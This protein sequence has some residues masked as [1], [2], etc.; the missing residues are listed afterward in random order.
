MRLATSHHL[1]IWPA[2]FNIRVNDGEV[3]IVNDE[4]GLVFKPGDTVRVTGG[5][6]DSLIVEKYSGRAIPAGCGGPYLL[7]GVIAK[8][9]P[10]S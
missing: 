6:V 8:W 10:E 3:Q 1:I 7:A 9:D 5:E 4:K 2:G